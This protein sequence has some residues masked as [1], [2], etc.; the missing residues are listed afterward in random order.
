MLQI[1]LNFIYTPEDPRGAFLYELGFTY[2]QSV[3]NQINDPTV[4][5]ASLSSENAESLFDADIIVGY[6]D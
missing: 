6:G 1:L 4:Y 5:S 2:P 3:I